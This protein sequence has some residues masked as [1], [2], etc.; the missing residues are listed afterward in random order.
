MRKINDGLTRSQRYTF[1]HPERRKEICKNWRLRNPEY[2]KQIYHRTKLR[3]AVRLKA[4][5][6][7]YYVK[8]SE[9]RKAYVRQYRIN[10]MDKIKT[11]LKR[12]DVHY[13]KMKEIPKLSRFRFSVSKSG[14]R[15]RGLGWNISKS[16]YEEII[17][18]RCEYCDGV[19]NPYGSGLDRID[20]S[21]GY[22]I[23][24]VVPCCK[25]CNWN[26][27]DNLTHEEMKIAMRA[28]LDYRLKT[29]LS[30]VNSSGS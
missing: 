13:R 27:C 21:K 9:E 26:R 22:V 28:V 5:S 2:Q 6:R 17:S 24:N 23:G 4:K 16:D 12:P 15:R 10:N 3:D 20:N 25:K 1:R 18:R 29:A 30:G 7:R 11:Y 19:L 14:A 8:H